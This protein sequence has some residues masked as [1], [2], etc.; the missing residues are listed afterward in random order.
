MLVNHTTGVHV[1][2]CCPGERQQN[3]IASF[4]QLSNCLT[5]KVLSCDLIPDASRTLECIV[6]LAAKICAAVSDK[7]LHN[8]CT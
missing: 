5:Y 2:I 7:S 3:L 8:Y 6:K 1:V 4:Q